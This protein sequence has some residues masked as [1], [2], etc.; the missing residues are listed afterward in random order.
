LT[1]ID[2]LAQIYFKERWAEC[3]FF[4]LTQPI[5]ACSNA[6]NRQSSGMRNR[7]SESDVISERIQK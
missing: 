3:E 7:I 1:R 6:E 2:L 5:A 4:A